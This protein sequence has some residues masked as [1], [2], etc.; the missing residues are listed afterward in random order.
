[1]RA[2]AARVSSTVSQA[3][4]RAMATGSTSNRSRSRAAITE[5]AEATDTSCSPERP[6]NSTTTRSLRRAVIG[7]LSPGWLELA[8]Q[9]HFPLQFDAEPLAHPPFCQLDQLPHL[10]RRRAAGVTEEVGVLGRDFG[11]ADA[12]PA[13]ADLV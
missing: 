1:M 7:F 6:P 4:E 5:R 2:S 13:Q 12:V 11:V 3:P 9:L 10:R 8:H